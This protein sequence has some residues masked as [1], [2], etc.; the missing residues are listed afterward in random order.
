MYY[1]N[2]DIR[3]EELPKPKIVSGELLVQVKACGICGSDV[4]EWYRIRKAPCVLGHEITGIVASVGENVRHYKVND[5]VFVSHHVPCNRCYYCLHNLHTV[6]DTLHKTNIDPGGFAE[7]IRVP[8]INVAHGL[9]I[10]PESITFE[11]GVLIEP[12]ACTVRAQRLAGLSTGNSLLVIGTGV[13]GLLHI[14]LARVLGTTLIIAVDLHEYRLKAAENAGVDKT[15]YAKDATPEELLKLNEGRLP[16]KVIVCT[17]S[18]SAILQALKLVDKGGTLLFFA[19]TEPGFAI[20][21][22]L[23]S[24]FFRG[25]TLKTSYAASPYDLMVALKL[26]SSGRVKVKELITHKLSLA[27]TL[28]GFQLV[29]KAQKSLKVIIEPER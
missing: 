9:Y 15:I 19:P 27:E 16:D 25:L 8:S 10:L 22:E 18:E 6:C 29:I 23:N 7:Y 4:M 12:L 1:R 11:E 26:I 13:A 24:L 2:D 14:K 28:Q 21:I 3:L 5:R 20:P 17:S